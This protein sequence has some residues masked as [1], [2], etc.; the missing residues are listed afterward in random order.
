ME[1]EL[2]PVD[3][4]CFSVQ[5]CCLIYVFIAARQ[6][7]AYA[8]NWITQKNW[9]TSCF[10]NSNSNSLSRAKQ[11][12]YVSSRA[13]LS[14]RPALVGCMFNFSHMQRISLRQDL[15]TCCSISNTFED[16]P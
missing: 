6:S 4:P 3:P 11:I 16:G 2:L 9:S 15:D 1:E 13:K 5:D 12:S 8:S 7:S 14:R 10:F